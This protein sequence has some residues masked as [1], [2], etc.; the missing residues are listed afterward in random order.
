MSF[1]RNENMA[2][3]ALRV[4]THQSIGDPKGVFDVPEGYAKL[5][6]GTPGWEVSE[7]GPMQNVAVDPVE[8]LRAK[9]ASQAPKPAPPPVPPEQAREAA[10]TAA[11]EAT[12]NLAASKEAQPAP[13][14]PETEAAE[15]GSDLST[16]GAVEDP[17][18]KRGKQKRK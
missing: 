9:Q 1:I 15:P 11:A 7:Q 18:K 16:P 6:V 2:G 5:L 13:P 17:P 14:A 3:Q 8:A 4:G 10:E 12:R